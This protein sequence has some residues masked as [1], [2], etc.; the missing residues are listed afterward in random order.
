[1][2]SNKEEEIREI[3]KFL[4]KL[5][6]LPNGKRIFN[7]R[8]DCIIQGK[9][10]VGIEH[11]RLFQPKTSSGIIIQAQEAKRDE[12]VRR[13]KEIYDESEN[14]KILRISIAFSDNYRIDK[15]SEFGKEEINQL[16]ASIFKIINKNIP[17]SGKKIKLSVFDG[18]N[19][20]H[21][22]KSIV[23]WNAGKKYGSNWVRFEGVTTPRI[24]ESIIQK[25]INSH[26]DKVEEYLKRC[27]KIWLLIIENNYSFSRSLNFSVK[28]DFLDFR[29]E[30]NFDKVFLFRNRS[31]TIFKLKSQK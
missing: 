10:K 28:S 18:D 30:Y 3:K 9:T 21:G 22:L 1:M 23:I 19:L 16:P 20:P 25:A 24:S 6:D 14:S 17:D 12:I 8:P 4:S 26:N 13:A 27:E 31:G 5:E 2:S 29:Y 11:T 7:E 15:N